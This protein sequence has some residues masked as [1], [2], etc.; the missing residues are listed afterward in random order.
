MKVGLRISYFMVLWLGTTTLWATHESEQEVRHNKVVMRMIGHEILKHLGDDT[1]RVLAIEYVNNRYRIPLEQPISFKP[2]D[3]IGIVDSVLT[4][5][6]AEPKCI[7]ETE[8]CETNEI[9]HSFE[10]GGNGILPC[11]GR[12]MP[13]DCYH[14]WITF[15]DQPPPMSN[16]VAKGSMLAAMDLNT[17]Y[18]KFWWIFPLV[19]ILSFLGFMFFRQKKVINE[20]TVIIGSYTF[21]TNAMTLT[22]GKEKTDLSHKE[23]ALLALLHASSNELVER[24]VILREIWGDDGDYVGRTLDVFIS[25][26]RKK[27]EADPNLRIIN[28][29]GVGYRLVLSEH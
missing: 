6:G 1:S 4:A 5:S 9:V 16:F 14:F 26:L 21:D 11:G 2:A 8:E 10:L 23:T 13:R 29:R 17:S 24:Q 25:K 7:V 18:S 20:D 22:R 27:L 15:L 12:E 3:I 19:L 28:I